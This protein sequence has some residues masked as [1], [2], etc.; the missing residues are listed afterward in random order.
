MRSLANTNGV[1][2]ACRPLARSTGLW[3]SRRHRAESPEAWANGSCLSTAAAAAYSRVRRSERHISSSASQW[4]S[5]A[6]PSRC[7]ARRRFSWSLLRF[8]KS[9]VSRTHLALSR[10]AKTLCS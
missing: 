1:P 10:A 9:R 5:V 6:T 3:L 7:M 4:A 2:A 8:S